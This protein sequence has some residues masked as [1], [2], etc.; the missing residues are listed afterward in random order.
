MKFVKKYFIGNFNYPWIHSQESET[1]ERLKLSHNVIE[2][3]SFKL[4][5]NGDIMQKAYF[6]IKKVLRMKLVPGKLLGK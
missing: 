4:C 5:K 1:Q 2:K 3:S 6:V